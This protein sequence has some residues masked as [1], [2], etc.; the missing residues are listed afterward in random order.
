MIIVGVNFRVNNQIIHCYI[1]DEPNCTSRTSTWLNVEQL[2][3]VV[4][5][6]VEFLLG[7]RCKT[8]AIKIWVTTVFLM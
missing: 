7:K 8:C 3:Q 6:R 4:P 1:L 2:V 5:M